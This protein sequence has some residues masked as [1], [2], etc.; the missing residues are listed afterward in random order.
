MHHTGS[1]LMQQAHIPCSSQFVFMATNA[2]SIVS[3]LIYT[4]FKRVSCSTDISTDWNQ[5]IRIKAEITCLC[6]DDPAPVSYAMNILIN[7]NI[8]FCCSRQD[9]SSTSS[10]T[11]ATQ[12]KAVSVVINIPVSLCSPVVS[13]ASHLPLRPCLSRVHM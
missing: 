13:A 2:Q 12:G 7:V 6:C 3:T 8:D 5:R 9:R 1:K 11:A 4:V 10:H